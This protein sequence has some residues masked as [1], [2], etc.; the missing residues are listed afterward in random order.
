MLTVHEISEF[1]NNFDVPFLKRM[2]LHSYSGDNSPLRWPDISMETYEKISLKDIIRLCHYHEAIPSIEKFDFSGLNVLILGSSIP[3]AELYLMKKNCKSILTVEYREINWTL[4]KSLETKWK[5]IQYDDLKKL[6]TNIKFDVFFSYSSIEHSGLG[7]Y[8]DEIDP[9]GDLNTLKSV[10]P[11][12]NKNAKY[13]IA[14]PLGQ[15]AILF[16]RHRVYGKKRIS[17]I[18]R[19]I[20]K[21][22]VRFIE[23]PLSNDEEKGIG[24]IDPKI[25]NLLTIPVGHDGIQRLMIFED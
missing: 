20:G 5:A 17:S 10:M 24:K 4:P 15:D 3:W 23:L 8:G 21:G 18:A 16:N 13:L 1:T 2:H 19:T 22:K 25:N 14:V 9:N 6:E 12:M 11:L 7:R